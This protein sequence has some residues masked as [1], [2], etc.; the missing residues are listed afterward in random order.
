[1]VVK[2]IKIIKKPILIEARTGT[3]RLTIVE[4]ITMNALETIII[5]K[6]I[7]IKSCMDLNRKTHQALL[8]VRKRWL[9]FPSPKWTINVHNV[10]NS[11]EKSMQEN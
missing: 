4:V 3:M 6:I 9:L 7:M 1:M 10:K 2:T 11:L 8:K 5:R